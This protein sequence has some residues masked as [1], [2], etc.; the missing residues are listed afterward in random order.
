V[1]K[2]M[3]FA[4]VSLAELARKGITVHADAAKPVV[5]V[6]DDETLIADT[7]AA[8]L[9]RHGFVTMVAYDGKTALQ[10]ARTVPPDLLLTDVVMPG[11][12]GVDLAI[13]I[14]GF[15]PKCKVLLFSGQAATVDLLGAAGNA[16]RDFTIL[17]KPLHPKQL[18]ARLSHTLSSEDSI[19]ESQYIGWEPYRKLSA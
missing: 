8:I 15:L 19:S 16:G 1:A 17:S 11:M 9:F 3:T 12:T 18:I 2:S 10:I 13:A 7:L 5:L 4:T 6:V 14:R